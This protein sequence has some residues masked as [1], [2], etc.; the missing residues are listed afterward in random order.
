MRKMKKGVWTCAFCG[1]RNKKAAIECSL[2]CTE[3]AQQEFCT[4][5][6]IEE[7]IVAYSAYCEQLEEYQRKR[8]EEKERERLEEERKRLE[9]ERKRLEEEEKKAQ[10]ERERE[11]FEWGKKQKTMEENS[12]NC[13]DSHSG[14]WDRLHIMDLCY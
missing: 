7:S 6:I 5:E 11:E 14:R 9:E 8:L 3:L 1:T 4:K 2:C 13:I 10:E 12:F